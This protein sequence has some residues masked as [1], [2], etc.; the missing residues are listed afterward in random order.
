LTAV[1]A[2]LGEPSVA[3]L[4]G[5]CA[6]RLAGRVDAGADAG[7]AFG[8]TGIGWALASFGG[9]RLDAARVAL[10]R[11]EG[12][13]RERSWHGWCS[14]LAGRAIARA[15]AAGPEPDP[16]LDHAVRV[17]A[18]RPVLR[19]LSLCHGELGVAEALTVLAARTPVAA[20]ARRRRAG[21]VLDAIDRYGPSCGTPNAVPTPGLLGGLAGIG[22][23]LLRLGFADRV[24]SALLLES[25]PQH[26]PGA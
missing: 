6:D 21:L 1:H 15:A 16:D 4:A 2:E 5:A 23:G 8:A 24:P 18:D 7:F 12:S 9:S 25:R 19:N 14:G 20:A 10:D 3:G 11:A 13:R 22:Y 17:L 26:G